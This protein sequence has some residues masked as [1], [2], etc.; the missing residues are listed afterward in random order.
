MIYLVEP[1]AHTIMNQAEAAYRR[2]DLLKKRL[3]LMND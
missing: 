2:N 3:S 1:I